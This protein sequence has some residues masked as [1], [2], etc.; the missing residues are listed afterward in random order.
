LHN[1]KNNLINV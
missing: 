1:N